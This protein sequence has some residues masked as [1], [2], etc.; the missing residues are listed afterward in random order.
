MGD[1]AWRPVLLASLLQAADRVDSTAGVQMAY[2]K[3]WS[4]R[5]YKEL[6]LR[7]PELL[8]GAGIT[9]HADAAATAAHLPAA[10]LAYLDPPYN[11]H[12][13]GG[14]YHVW[15]T[16]MAWDARPT[17]GWRASGSTCGTMPYERVQPAAG[18]PGGVGPARGL[19]SGLTW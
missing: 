19:G 2:L 17:T 15:E 6:E 13:Y 18:S 4:P 14:N 10:D 1:H 11:Q 3:T 9:F 12:R 7:V 8:P 5:S 16:L